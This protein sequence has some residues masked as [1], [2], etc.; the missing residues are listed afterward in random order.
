MSVYNAELYLADAIKSILE[1][2]YRDF[3][4]IIIDDGSTDRS[5]EIVKS[6]YDTRIVFLQQ[7]NKGLAYSLNR[8]IRE[9]R[10]KYIARMDADDISAP[11]RLEK[12]VDF[13]NQNPK[14]ILVGCNGIQIDEQ[15][16]YLSKLYRSN[17]REQI[18]K[19]L[20]LGISPF[21]HGSVIFKKEFALVSGL[22]DE[23]KVTFEDWDL[24]M[25]MFSRGDMT[26][27]EESLYSY[28]LTPGS[29]TTLP[30]K[31]S[32][33][34][35][36]IILNAVSNGGL[37]EG[38]ISELTSLKSGLSFLNLIAAYNLRVGKS[39]LEDEWRPQTARIYLYKAIKAS[40]YNTIP[41]VNLFLTF[42]PRLVVREWK[43]L[44]L[45]RNSKSVHY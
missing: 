17:S 38:E 7:P 26:N 4:F 41:W 6:F 25:K 42:L 36:A 30:P 19:E 10:G 22:Y 11:T 44:R 5:I 8:G 13:L 1:Q 34:R 3:E 31:Q 21:I 24:W 14:Y 43:N 40:P 12:Q 9:S 2:T 45:K 29:V 28:R 35:R 16:C 32:E 27:L 39:L 20:S 37:S 15:G 23:K 18:I 33:R